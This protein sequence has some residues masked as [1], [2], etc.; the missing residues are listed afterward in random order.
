MSKIAVKHEIL[1]DGAVKDILAALSDSNGL[2]REEAARELAALITPWI[3][4]VFIKKGVHGADVEAMTISTLTKI[5]WKLPHYEYRQ[6]VG[7]F[8]LWVTRVAANLFSDWQAKRWHTESLEDLE[9]RNAIPYAAVQ[10]HSDHSAGIENVELNTLIE[11]Y[12]DHLSTNES[13]VIRLRFLGPTHE[14]SEI[15]NI[16]NITTGNARVLSFRALRRL[17]KLLSS[18]PRLQKWLRKYQQHPQL[19][20]IYE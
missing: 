6:S 3:A 8:R 18:D 14:F 2:R 11:E 4:S 10:L 16:L 9:S 17:G 12:L 19:S 20:N 15:A 1:S 5:V 13:K 7:Q